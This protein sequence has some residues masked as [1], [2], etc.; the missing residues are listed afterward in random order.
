[1]TR[2]EKLAQTRYRNRII[3]T[4]VNANHIDGKGDILQV[5]WGGKYAG[6]DMSSIGMAV[7]LYQYGMDAVE[8]RIMDGAVKFLGKVRVILS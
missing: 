8:F 3:A 6:T 7:R 2:A 5:T 4:L 1:M